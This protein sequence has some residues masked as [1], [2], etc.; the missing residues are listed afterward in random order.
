MALSYAHILLGLAGIIPAILMEY[1][2]LTQKQA[3]AFIA[4]LL[5]GALIAIHERITE[6][7]EGPETPK[8]KNN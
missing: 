7:I 2:I 5:I 3:F 8:K 4:M 1:S 6:L